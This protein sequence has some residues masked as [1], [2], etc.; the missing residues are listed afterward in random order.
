MNTNT[1]TTANAL[2]Q[3]WGTYCTCPDHRS[4]NS[5]C[6]HILY[7]MRRILGMDVSGGFVDRGRIQRSLNARILLHEYSVQP[8][9][10]TATATATS[11]TSSIIATSTSAS[12]SAS[13]STPPINIST[14][15]SS[16]S[17]VT[18]KE[19]EKEK[20]KTI[21]SQVASSIIIK[22]VNDTIVF[23]VLGMTSEYKVTF[24]LRNDW[25]YIPSNYL[26]TSNWPLTIDEAISRVQKCRP[27]TDPSLEMALRLQQEFDDEEVTI[28]S[29]TN[30]NG[31]TK[32][33]DAKNEDTKNA[34]LSR[35][36][37]R[38]RQINY[39]P[40]EDN[41]ADD[42][43]SKS[44]EFTKKKQKKVS[45]V[46]VP[47]K[48]FIGE[49]CPICL[50]SFTNECEVVYCKSVCGRS[51]HT[52]CFARLS[53]FTKKVTCPLCRAPMPKINNNKTK[54]RTKK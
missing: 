25:M 54:K 27:I 52:M 42:D 32:N 26:R 21:A 24:R 44:D 45:S 8:S 53:E 2:K 28:N 22:P 23:S 19:K 51:C 6:K 43:F 1:A 49:N 50:E 38:S 5:T 3:W 31:D 9:S 40:P 16:L 17:S 7:V 41:D 4:R 15:S 11:S 14:S 12:A 39:A 10:A 48:P 47:Q 30:T 34:P 35:L 20:E 18:E 33:E 36:R 29:H 46:C 37:K 13:A